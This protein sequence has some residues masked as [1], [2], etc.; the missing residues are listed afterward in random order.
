MKTWL[1]TIN[2]DNHSFKTEDVEI[3]FVDSEDE[4]DFSFSIPSSAKKDPFLKVVE[5]IKDKKNKTFSF[6]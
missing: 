5:P 1:E 3:D 6:I 4:E 2:E